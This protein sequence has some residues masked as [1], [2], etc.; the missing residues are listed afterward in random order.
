MAFICDGFL[1]DSRIIGMMCR[2]KVDQE[3]GAMIGLAFDVDLSAMS[4]DDFQG[5]AEAQAHAIPDVASGEEGVKDLGLVF[6]GD[7]DTV[8]FQPDL[9]ASGW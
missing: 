9:D 1:T 7:P 8:V 5:E 6:G 4:L 2:G 3:G